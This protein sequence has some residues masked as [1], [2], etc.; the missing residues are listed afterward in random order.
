V[1][2]GEAQKSECSPLQGIYAS[3]PT[4]MR[5]RS[6]S[7][8]LFSLIA[9]SIAFLL[10][11]AWTENGKRSAFLVVAIG[12]CRS[13]LVQR[14][15]DVRLLQPFRDCHADAPFHFTSAPTSYF[16]FPY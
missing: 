14:V 12:Q 6:R 9:R 16:R 10:S 13:E 11:R 8:I 7:G 1:T 15:N 5:Q 4:L 2:V 3:R